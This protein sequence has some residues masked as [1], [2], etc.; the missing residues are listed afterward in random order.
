[1]SYTSPEPPMPP[2]PGDVQRRTQEGLRFL[3]FESRFVRRPMRDSPLI[4]TI[5]KSCQQSSP[6]PFASASRH[7]HRAR[8][9]GAPLHLP[10]DDKRA[11][12]STQ[13]TAGDNHA[14]APAIPGTRCDSLRPARSGRRG[15]LRATTRSSE[16]GWA[17][18]ALLYPSSCTPCPARDPRDWQ[19]RLHL[20]LFSRPPREVCEGKGPAV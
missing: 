3:A 15:I 17:L 20:G 4:A 16:L 7:L 14:S 18:G 2:S 12:I 1:M 13:E 19:G 5:N 8:H 6:R 11:I 9:R 10:E